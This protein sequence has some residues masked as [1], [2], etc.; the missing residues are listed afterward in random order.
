MNIIQISQKIASLSQR[1]GGIFLIADLSNLLGPMSPLAFMRS[2]RQLVKA[3]V[4]I[5]IQR[6]IYAT[7]QF[8]LWQLAARVAPGA[9]VSMDNI[10]ARNGLVGTVPA[11]S[12][13]LVDTRRGRTLSTSGGMIRSFSIQPELFFGF[14]R[15][16]NGIAVASSEK[17]FLDLLYFYTKGHRFVIDPRSEVDTSRLD[18]GQLMRYLKR[19]KNPKFVRFVKGVCDEKS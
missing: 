2:V 5:K 1:L 13:S 15:E 18:H 6:G 10:L 8:D 16:K 12:L 14:A 19:Y 4:L 11:Y 7:P 3:G 17:A 9:Y